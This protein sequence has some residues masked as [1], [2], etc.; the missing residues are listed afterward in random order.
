MR[1]YQAIAFALCVELILNVA[2]S[3]LGADLA[4]RY[5]A[6][7][8]FSDQPRGYE[9]TCGPEDVWRLKEFGYSLGDAFR[10]KLG[11]SQVVF[12]RHESNVVWAAVFPDRPGEIL[13]ASPGKGEHVTS[14]W[15]RFHPARLGELFPGRFLDR[16]RVYSLSQYRNG[17]KHTDLGPKNERACGPSGAWHYAGPVVVLLGQKTISSAESFALALAQ[18]PQVVTLGDRTAGS[19]GDPRR[20]DAGAGIVVN[21]PRWIDMDP[22]GKPIDAV[23]GP[24]PGGVLQRRPG[25]E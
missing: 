20:V 24:P 7:L 6:T 16:R 3:A 11:P 2:A 25:V 9:W 18:C 10:V 1:P 12:G 13:A 22:A 4:A 21:L 5:R 8:D 17:P 15:L 14:I 23:G 19:S